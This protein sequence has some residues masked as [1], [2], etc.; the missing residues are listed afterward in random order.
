M[1][2]A[3]TKKDLEEINRYIQLG[4]D[5]SEMAARFNDELRH[6]IKIATNGEPQPK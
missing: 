2:M 5:I 6:K 3:D 4:I 1:P